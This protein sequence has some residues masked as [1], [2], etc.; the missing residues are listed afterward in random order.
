M[1]AVAATAAAISGIGLA[2]AASAAATI[3]T[4]EAT[5]PIGSFLDT[6]LVL[7]P[8]TTYQFSVIDPSTLW[9]AGS[10]SP[11]SRESTASGIPASRGYGQET[12]DGY[13]FNFGALVGELGSKFFLIGTN[14]QLSGLSGDLQVGYWDSFYPDNSGSQTLSISAPVPE[15]AIWAM[16][17]LGAGLVGGGLRMARRKN[18]MA[19]A[20]T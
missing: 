18:D 8:T 2:S 12:Q 6:G 13:T 16:M 14:A 15:P 1:I 5:T 20:A 19:L 9:S 4:V 3:V 11:F 10:N 7:S 17:F